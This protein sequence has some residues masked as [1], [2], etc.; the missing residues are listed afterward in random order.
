MS[1]P[2][3]PNN[4]STD[5]PRS[6][7]TSS[8]VFKFS[9]PFIV[10]RIILIGLF[11]PSDF[12]KISPTPANSS[13]A[14]TGPPEITPVPS[15]AGFNKTFPAPNSPTI[16]CGIVVPT[17]GT[18]M[19][20]F[21]ASSIAF[22]IASG[23][24]S[25]FPVPNPTCPFLSPTTTSAAKRKRRPPF[26]TLATR[27]IV[28]TRSSSSSLFGSMFCMKECPPLPIQTPLLLPL[29]LL[30]TQSPVRGTSNLHDQNRPICGLFPVHVLHQLY[31]LLL[32][33]EQYR[34][35]QMSMVYVLLMH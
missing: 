1:F 2:P 25:A 20:L 15:A 19:R 11:D 21:F 28:T 3:Y 31:Q 13:T 33:P 9:N 12:V 30:P 5:F 24:S 29:L 35:I 10:A 27:L 4:S 8:A 17:I 14:R 32:R 34:L 6:F 22:L 18:S 7:A 26:T 16:S 23:T